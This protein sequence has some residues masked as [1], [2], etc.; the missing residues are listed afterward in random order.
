M[1][2]GIRKLDRNRHQVNPP[3][4]PPLSFLL[5]VPKFSL[6]ALISSPR[7]GKTLSSI[8]LRPVVQMGPK[9]KTKKKEFERQ[10]GRCY[11]AVFH[12]VHVTMAVVLTTNH[13]FAQLQ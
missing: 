8:C 12:S 7:N 6:S 2:K 3:L 13:R 10:G 4:P 11:R 1:K 9:R 5:P